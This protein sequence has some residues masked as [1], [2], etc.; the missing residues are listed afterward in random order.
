MG[1]VTREG[2]KFRQDICVPCHSTDASTYLK[3]AAFMDLA[4]EIA[5]W[6]AQELG[7]G[8]DD[9][10]VHHTAWVLSRMH[11]HFA[12]P[13]KWR[14]DVT[15][16]TWHKGADGLFYLRDFYLQDPEGHRLV[17][18][19]SS[20][21]VIDEL[22][23]RLVRPEEL[24]ERLS[25]EGLVVEDSIV[26]RAPKVA[27]PRGVEPEPAGEHTVVYSDIDLIGHT[28]NARY[29]VWAMDC[30]DYET[31]STRRVKEVYLNFNKETTPG[32]TVQLFRLKTEEEGA[33]VYY[34]EGRVDGKSTFTVK[35]VF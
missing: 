31:A 5:Y 28:N 17:T 3:P 1:S 8:Y 23:R 14:D 18:C 19:T 26:E 20:W 6:A 16:Y 35:L 13:P 2:Y 33:P 11:I 30:I 22:S 15:L 9:L 12:D 4:Q 34:V 27:M 7:F 21:V 32:T 29:M 24:Q 25:V 10:H